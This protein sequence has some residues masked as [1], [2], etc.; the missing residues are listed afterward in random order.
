MDV[1]DNVTAFEKLLAQIRER[2]LSEKQKGTLFENLILSFLS[3]EPFY[4]DLFERTWR[5]GEWA[6]ERGLSSSQDLG[7]DLVASIA[8]EQGKFCAVQCKFYK[9][10]MVI[11]KSHVNSF[12]AESGRPEFVSRLFVTTAKVSDA[13]RRTF[14]DQDKK[15]TTIDRDDLGKSVIDWSRHNLDSPSVSL[16]PKKRLRPHQ[17]EALANI[18]TGFKDFDR[19]QI[20][21]ACGTGKTL[22]SLKIA[23]KTGG[24]G[25][26]VLYLVPGIALLSQTITEWTQESAVPLHSFAV[27]SDAKVGRVAQKEDYDPSILLHELQY[28]ATT[29]PKPLVKGVKARLDK[30]HLVVV[31]STYQSIEVIH[32]A[33][34]LGLPAFDVALCDE[35]HRTTGAK[36]HESDEDESA[37]VKIHDD[38]YIQA[39]KR[40]YMTATP[41]IFAVRGKS[42]KFD[43]DTVTLFS[44]DKEEHYG[45]VFHTLSFTDAVRRKLLADYK[46]VVLSMDESL[47]N[48]QVEILKNP[49]N[50]LVV[51]DA[52]LIVGC[53]KAL[54]KQ[55]F[56]A[57]MPG[58]N[59]E[60]MKRAVAY[61]QV[62]D[63]KIGRSERGLSRHKISSKQIAEYFAPVVEDYLKKSEE[64][65]WLRTLKCE[66]NHVDGSMSAEEKKEKLKWLREDFQSGTCRIL[67]NVRCLSEGVDVPSL[68]AVVFL[69]PRKSMVEIVQSVGRVMRM[70]P[71][72]ELGYVILP[73]VI[74]ANIEP[75]E[76]LNNNITYKV[77]WDV[78]QALRSHDN[79]FDEWINK[80]KFLNDTSGKIELI[81]VMDYDGRLKSA[82]P[83]KPGK[84]IVGTA[85]GSH[86]IG[87]SSDSGLNANWPRLFAN[88][89]EYGKAILAKLVKKVGN[90]DYLGEWA[91]DVVRISNTFIDRINAILED[92]R[93]SQEIKVFNSF[94][95]ELRDDLNDSL[96][97]GEII[98]MLAQ[99]M[100][101]GPAFE[102]IFENSTFVK[103][104]P[105]SVSINKVLETFSS[106]H[107]EKEAM[108][109][110]GFYNSV[111]KEVS[112]MQNKVSGIDNVLGKQKIV[113]E[114]YDKFFRRAF[115]K[116]TA[117]LGIVYT[118]V[119]IVD[120]I[121]HSVEDL[122]HNEFGQSL[123]SR[124]VH[125]IDPF[126]GTG[127]FVSRLLQSG[128]IDKKDLP[129]KYLN[130]IH[131]NEIV[132]LA[133][134]IA[135]INIESVYHEIMGGEYT[136]FPGI[137]LTDTFQLY[138]KDDL[139]SRYLEDNSTRRKIQKSLPLRVLISNP[140]Y[141][142]GQKSQNDNNKNINYP[143][144]DRHIKDSYVKRSNAKLLKGV[145]DSYVRAFRWASD[146]L[147]NENA[148]G[149]IGFVSNSGYIDKPT[150]DGF[151][152]SLA[153]DFQSIYVINLRGD[154]RKN[155][156]SGGSA[157]EGDNVFGN[158]SM[159]GIAITF[160]IKNSSK[161]GNTD[162]Y[163]HNI[164][165]SVGRT[166]KLNFLRSY[167]SIKSLIKYNKLEKI[168]PNDNGDWINQRDDSFSSHIV[169]GEKPDR[170]N[171]KLFQNYSLGVVTNR[172]A[173]CYNFS[174]NRLENN[175]KGMINFYN[176]ERRRFNASFLQ[177]REKGKI[178]NIDNFINN[179]KNKISWTD[180]LKKELLNN[181]VI[182]YDEC[183]IVQSLYRPFTK[184]WFY[185]NRKMNERVNQ[186]PQLFPSEDVNNKLICVA[187]PGG[188][189]QFSVLASDFLPAL[190]YVEN[191]QCFP[192]YLYKPIDQ[193]QGKLF[194]INLDDQE[195][196]KEYAITKD[197]LTHFQE[198]YPKLSINRKE[199]F[200]YI[201]GILHSE[202]YRERF[203][204][205]LTKELPRIPRVKKAKYFEA[206]RDAGKALMDLHINYETVKKQPVEIVSNG[207]LSDEDYYV[208]KMKFAKSANA[209][210]LSTI[211]YNDRI[212]IKGVPLEAHKYVIS[213]KS[214][215]G[216]VMKYQGVNVDKASQIVNDANLWAIET[217]DNPKYPLELLQRVITVSLE[218]LNI[219]SGLPKLDID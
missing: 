54:A 164:G 30:N 112:A 72:K 106:H 182:S 2:A 39:K 175:M 158:T 68:D 118:P 4:Q 154:I 110:S 193:E 217:M 142:V 34:K 59:L 100:I 186:M 145:Y 38:N 78:L 92:Q 114:L 71:G 215:I 80:I 36:D 99:H 48:R 138:E 10:D 75:H 96:T 12:L 181:T 115:P 155:M 51:N 32:Q 113:I 214:P 107:L 22:I 117:R 105:V 159:T 8:G 79:S 3:H 125:I 90:P 84:D 44:M 58:A 168:V 6:K 128:L 132:L 190:H 37:F 14:V 61:C 97:K 180:N 88:D 28:P 29:D 91:D 188:R 1:Y 120:F 116:M 200:H 89:E 82:D 83:S 174:R 195:F 50:T 207:R 216:W 13:V 199:L 109:L 45:P 46:V 212:T 202:D 126:T 178:I 63:P 162:V 140:P 153:D 206:F 161:G 31:F 211:I 81:S 108:G 194:Q 18:L 17:E 213:G 166:E 136:P 169:F 20:H 130:E 191:G 210:D 163:Y 52:A 171:I 129:Y 173:W 147:K 139:I 124:D 133:Y 151:R 42:G 197:G 156:L 35:A 127:S 49:D 177:N 9:D 16:R 15:V 11:Q 205:N 27:C 103:N 135:S 95:D 85:K 134:Y 141:S 66:T 143:N 176:S 47:I 102:A 209:T 25:G 196:G 165:D 43:S 7:I 167:P 64:E 187:G 87:Q 57:D 101:T 192:Y 67:T 146:R 131:A 148:D 204:D 122:L 179:D 53:F 218:T 73:V 149:I 203:G 19:G 62:I 94:A 121:I 123:S 201:Y 189:S 23:E 40:L 77:V 183:S 60:P 55:G 157:K 70:S 184:T 152:K 33:Q 137:C 144:L 160:L 170:G 198:F 24:P 21:M 26:L 76:A 172:D 93:N 208:E 119:E 74:P 86:E 104:N 56:K 65:S 5:Y 219:V 150:M 98:E 111:K 185:Y 41:R 69:S